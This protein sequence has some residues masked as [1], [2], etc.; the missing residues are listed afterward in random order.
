[1]DEPE[2]VWT[3]GSSGTLTRGLQSMEICKFNVVM[4]GHKGDYGRAKVY[5]SSYEFQSR[6]KF[7]PYPSA[8]TYDAKVWEL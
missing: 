5:K 3:V 1:M 6:P 4:H 2:E 8:P 7:T